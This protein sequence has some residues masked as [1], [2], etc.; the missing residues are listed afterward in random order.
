MK[1]ISLMLQDFCRK[2]KEREEEER[3][4]KN[5]PTHSAVKNNQDNK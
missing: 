2:R 1:N 4:K 5:N 3:E